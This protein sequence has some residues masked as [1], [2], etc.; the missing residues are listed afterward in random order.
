MKRR[1]YKI[2]LMVCLMPAVFF[3]LSGCQKKDDS[4]MQKASA[5]S[6][7]SADEVTKAG[8]G[9]N[10]YSLNLGGTRIF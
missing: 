3:L 10:H 6:D 2:I 4:E 9:Q 5:V 1:N 8:G 7:A